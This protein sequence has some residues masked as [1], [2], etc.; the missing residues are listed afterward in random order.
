MVRFYGF[1]CE[2]G[3]SV[4]GLIGGIHIRLS[5]IGL[6]S[7]VILDRRSDGVFDIRVSY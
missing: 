4:V 2:G 1:V 6:L 5:E 7:K 3:L